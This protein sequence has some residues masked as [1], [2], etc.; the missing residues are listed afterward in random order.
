M[1]PMQLADVP[2]GS[3]VGWR[4]IPSLLILRAKFHMRLGFNAGD[5]AADA[6]PVQGWFVAFD[7]RD[8]GCK[9]GFVC[10]RTDPNGKVNSVSWD[11]N[12]IHGFYPPKAE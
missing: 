9:D 7:M 3:L 8:D 4:V 12:E 11:A 2:P 6:I 1:I 5:R 10:E